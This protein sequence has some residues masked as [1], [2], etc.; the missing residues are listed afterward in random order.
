MQVDKYGLPISEGDGGDSLHHYF[1]GELRLRLA[2][3]PIKWSLKDQSPQLKNAV[4]GI[5]K[6]CSTDDAFKN[7]EVQP[8]IYIRNPDPTQ[9]VSDPRNVSRDQLT[10]VIAFLSYTTDKVRL[11]NLLKACLKRYMFAQNIYPNWVD[12]RTQAVTAKT[13]DFIT[14][15]LWTLFAR[16]LLGAWSWPIN[17]FLDIFILLSV[18]FKLW[19][20]LSVDGTLTF[21]WPGPGDTDDDNMHNVLMV[22]QYRYPTPLSWFARKLFKKYRKPNFGNTQMGEKDPMMGALVWYYR[23]SIGEDPEFAEIARPIVERY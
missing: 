23:A 22:S 15:D 14:P 20:P 21:R 5:S 3:N 13:P 17:F 16:G 9:W 19:A 1:T 4:D 8:G 10:A 12:P 18:I 6:L 11:W 2:M 7:L